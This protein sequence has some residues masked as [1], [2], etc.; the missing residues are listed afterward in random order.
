M[1]KEL[2]PVVRS[3]QRQPVRIAEPET[4]EADIIWSADVDHQTFR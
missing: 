1:P 4:N 3:S 2:Q